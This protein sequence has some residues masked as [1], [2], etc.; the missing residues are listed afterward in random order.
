M[1]RF[2]VAACVGM[3]CLA[4]APG[5]SDDFYKAIRTTPPPSLNFRSLAPMSTSRT[6]VATRRSCTPPPSAARP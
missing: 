5:V 1:L 4:A 2:P 6:T 3:S